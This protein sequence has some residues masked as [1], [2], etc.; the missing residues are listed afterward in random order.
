MTFDEWWNNASDYEAFAG[1]NGPTEE[2]QDAYDREV[3]RKIDEAME[4]DNG[5]ARRTQA[6]SGAAALGEDPAAG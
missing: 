2:E 1:L 4:R 3:E 5:A 6:A